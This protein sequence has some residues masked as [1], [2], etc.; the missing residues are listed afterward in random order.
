MTC[1]CRTC[2]CGLLLE[3]APGQAGR[4][5]VQDAGGQL[6]DGAQA[7][8]QGRGAASIDHHHLMHLLR[9]LVCQERTERHPAQEQNGHPG[10]SVKA[11]R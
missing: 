10:L 5:T 1:F 7:G 6:E 3:E 2:Y 11:C 8:L 4:Q 9:I